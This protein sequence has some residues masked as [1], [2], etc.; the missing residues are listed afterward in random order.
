MLLLVTWWWTWFIKVDQNTFCLHVTILVCTLISVPFLLILFGSKDYNFN[1][2][3]SCNLPCSAYHFAPGHPNLST[4]KTPQCCA[5]EMKLWT[6]FHEC[7]ETQ[8]FNTCTDLYYLVR[9]VEHLKVWEYEIY[10]FYIVLWPFIC[11]WQT[12]EQE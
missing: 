1:A 7:I 10:L 5:A 6:Q 12:K 3:I 2:L 4:G 11:K 8:T 9:K